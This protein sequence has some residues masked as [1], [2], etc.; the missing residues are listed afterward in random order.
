MHELLLHDLPE[1]VI[2][3]WFLREGEQFT[4]GPLV[5]LRAQ[6]CTYT[7]MITENDSFFQGGTLQRIVAAA[8]TPVSKGSCLALLQLDEAMLVLPESKTCKPLPAQGQVWFFS[9]DPLI[10]PAAPLHTTLVRQCARYRCWYRR[11][12]PL[13]EL[14][15]SAIA[16]GL[17]AGSWL[18]LQLLAG[19]SLGD[20]PLLFLYARLSFWGLLLALVGFSLL[21]ARASIQMVANARQRARWREE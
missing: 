12:Y 9:Y 18:L 7:V 15:T 8:G 11:W 21:L 17:I 5:S 1:G 16:L 13:F 19:Q 4:P 10:H 2:S 14:R 3:C 20:D 6:A